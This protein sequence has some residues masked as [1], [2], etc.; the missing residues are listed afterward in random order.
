MSARRSRLARGFTL[1]ELLTVIAIITLLISILIPSLNAARTHAKNART[2]ALLSAIKAGAELFRNESDRYPRSWSKEGN[3]F[4]G[5]P[6]APGP[7]LSGAQWLALQLLGADLQGAVKPTVQND[8][9]ENGLIDKKDW[10]AWYSANPP[11]T[12]GRASLY[13]TTDPTNVRTPRHILKEN[14]EAAPAP[15]LLLGAEDGGAGGASEWNNGR[16]PM[17]VDAFGAPVLY[18]EAS[19]FAEQPYSTGSGSALVQ[20]RYDQSHNAMITGADAQNGQVSVSGDNA[21]GWNLAG[22]TPPVGKP[23]HPL[24][25]FGYRAGDTTWPPSDSFAAVVS[26][27]AIFDTTAQGNTPQG[28]IWPYN[29][30]LYLL[31]AAGK[32]GL[33]GTSD[34]IRNFGR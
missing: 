2:A 24:G 18:Y 25:T 26:D 28:R 21:A 34:D 7:P 13:V 9:D 30:E 19:A 11:R 3:P 29:P 5:N 31:I 33:Y 8:S 12:F 15:S 16:L 22:I 4:E 20:G 14:P 10:L 27:R 23:V 17:F 1:V 6:N 32:D